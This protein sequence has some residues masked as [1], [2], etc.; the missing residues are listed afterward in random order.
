LNQDGVSI[1]NNKKVRIYKR[2]QHS[3]KDLIKIFN[4]KNI[5][6]NFQQRL[7]SYYNEAYDEYYDVAENHCAI[8]YPQYDTLKFEDFY[9]VK[10]D[11]LEITLHFSECFLE[12]TNIGHGEEWAYLVADNYNNG[13]QALSEAYHKL[14]FENPQQAKEELHIHCKFLNADE[15]FTNY[16]MIVFDEKL[17]FKRPIERTNDYT[18]SYKAQIESGKSAIYAHQYADLLAS[19]KYT[20]QYC[21]SYAEHYEYYIKNGESEEQATLS[22]SKYIESNIIKE[23]KNIKDRLLE[24][25]RDYFLDQKMTAKEISNQVNKKKTFFK[26]I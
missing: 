4:E 14:H 8:Y 26:N 20:E 22:T 12:Q 24:R 3:K 1:K 5:P 10:E 7:V 2:S 19:K 9:T 6:E 17:D 18:I 15:L 11:V 23:F 21:H 13:E 16:L 25:H